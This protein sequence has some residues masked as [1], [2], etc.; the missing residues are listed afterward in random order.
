MPV[1]SCPSVSRR[2]LIFCMRSSLRRSAFSFSLRSENCSRRDDTTAWLRALAL[3]R[4]DL[5]Q[6][7]A[8]GEEIEIVE[9]GEQMHAQA[10]APATVAI[11]F[12]EEFEYFEF[13]NDVF[14]H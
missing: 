2:S 7:S 4:V 5:L 1:R 3:R 10:E 13:A 6:E 9:A 8:R 12:G 11:A 14:T